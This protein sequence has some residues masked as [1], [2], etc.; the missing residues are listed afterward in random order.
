MLSEDRRA[1]L[2]YADFVRKQ[3][4]PRLETSGSYFM[5]FTFDT[6]CGQD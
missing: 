3:K 4:L 2:I 5:L 6:L 1:K